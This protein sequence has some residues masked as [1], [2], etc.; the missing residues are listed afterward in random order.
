M[1]FQYTTFFV[2]TLSITI[3]RMVI[4]NIKMHLIVQEEA[5]G[6]KK[7]SRLNSV[8]FLFPFCKQDTKHQHNENTF[9]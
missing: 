5:E 6:D 8:P 4:I 3:L 7:V 1:V 2:E 9:H